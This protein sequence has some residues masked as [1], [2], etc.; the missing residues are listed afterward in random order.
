MPQTVIRRAASPVDWAQAALVLGEQRAWLEG[1]L[2]ADLTTFQPESPVEY[3]RPDR[4]YVPPAGALLLACVGGDPA[5]VAGV[6]RKAP[7]VVELKRMYVR[8]RFRGLRLGQGL[9]DAS[10]LAAR[11]LG[12][13]TV[14]LETMPEEMATAQALYRGAGFRPVRDLAT[15]GVVAMELDLEPLSLAA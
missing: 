10:L 11:T 7:G 5:G 4:F 2:G 9:L 3:A 14:E 15:D 1:L 8:S 13:R 6:V 12:A